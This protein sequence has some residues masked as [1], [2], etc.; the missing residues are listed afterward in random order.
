MMRERLVANFVP[1]QLPVGS[2]EMFTGGLIDLIKM[3]FGPTKT[4]LWGTM[5]VEDRIP[6]IWKNA[7]MKG[8]EQLLE[9]VSIS[10]TP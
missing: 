3:K 9:A 10:M 2:G 6:T 7:L 4:I 5:F 8:R 1:V